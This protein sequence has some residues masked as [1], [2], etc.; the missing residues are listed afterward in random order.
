MTSGRR[1]TVRQWLG[2]D[3]PSSVL[4]AIVRDASESG[5]DGRALP[6]RCLLW[7]T[8]TRKI[9]AMDTRPQGGAD[10]CLFTLEW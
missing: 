6:G 8:G 7:V 10:F 2:V 1:W 4:S 9:H 3:C 5:V